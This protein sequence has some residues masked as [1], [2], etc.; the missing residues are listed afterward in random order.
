MKLEEVGEGMFAE[1][2]EDMALWRMLLFWP[3]FFSQFCTWSPLEGVCDG[4]S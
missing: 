1:L 3:M 2:A 4:I